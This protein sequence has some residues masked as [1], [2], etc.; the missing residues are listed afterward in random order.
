M[1]GG[2]SPEL[3]RDNK[4]KLAIINNI[5]RPLEVPDRG[6]LADLVWSDPSVN[7]N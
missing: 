2:L 4:E 1:H 5:K 6:L 7:K 3:T